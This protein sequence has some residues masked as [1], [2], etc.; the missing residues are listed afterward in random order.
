MQ[1][2][3]FSLYPRYAAKGGING[4]QGTAELV[5]EGR[6]MP[7]IGAAHR[8]HHHD[9]DRARRLRRCRASC[10]RRSRARSTAQ[11]IAR[12]RAKAA[13]YAKQFGY[14]GYAMREVNVGVRAA[15]LRAARR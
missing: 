10:A 15:G 4:W 5:I 7:A 12:Y 1:T 13:D 6:D 14:G 11:A 2:G 8:P 9:D 3:N